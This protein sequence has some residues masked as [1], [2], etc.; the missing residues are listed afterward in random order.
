MLPFGGRKAA[1]NIGRTRRATITGHIR[2]AFLRMTVLENRVLSADE[3][4]TR[5][6]KQGF[7]SERGYNHGYSFGLYLDERF[8][9]DLMAQMAHISGGEKM[10]YR[11]GFCRSKA[12]GFD[13]ETLHAD[14]KAHITQRYEEQAQTVTERGLVWAELALIE[15][16]LGTSRC[17]M[18]RTR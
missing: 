8:G 13:T 5:F 18:E 6:D 17:R 7:E 11:L 4:T 10:A 9:D 12:T 3:W 2:D 1:Q 14:W 15:A 16:K